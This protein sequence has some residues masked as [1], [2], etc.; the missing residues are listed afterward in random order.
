[1]YL[2]VVVVLFSLITFLSRSADDELFVYHVIVSYL[3]ELLQNVFSKQMHGEAGR[4]SAATT[5]L[6]G[7]FAGCVCW[8]VSYPQD[9]VKSRLQLQPLGSPRLYVPIS[10]ALPDG[11]FVHCFRS[12]VQREG[13]RALWKGFSPCLLRAFPA[14]AAGF[15]TYEK[16]KSLLQSFTNDTPH[17][18]PR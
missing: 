1:M 9:V 18:A 6:A 11:G 10:R 3:D 7:G 4:P 17:V 2:V 12:I 16:A 14:N 13:P 5:L 15:A 8:T